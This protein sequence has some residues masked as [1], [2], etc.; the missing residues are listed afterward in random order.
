MTISSYTQYEVR[1]KGSPAD[2]IAVLQQLP[3]EARLHL[4]M[5]RAWHTLD[6]LVFRTEEKEAT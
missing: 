3:P 4:V 2:I 5:P 6:R 1:I